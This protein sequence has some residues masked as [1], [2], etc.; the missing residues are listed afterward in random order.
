[1]ELVELPCLDS[2]SSSEPILAA[3]KTLLAGS[4]REALLREATALR[5]AA[6]ASPFVCRGL[7]WAEY[8]SGGRSCWRC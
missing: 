4:S 1:M 5:A 7:G 8:L 3:R 2:D 6:A